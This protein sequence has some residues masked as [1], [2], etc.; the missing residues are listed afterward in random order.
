M[1][2]WDHTLP[3]KE[4]RKSQESCTVPVCVLSVNK[5][6]QENKSHNQTLLLDKETLPTLASHHS[7][8]T[9]HCWKR[10]LNVTQPQFL[11]S[12]WDPHLL[13][14]D[15]DLPIDTSTMAKTGPNPGSASCSDWTR[16]FAMTSRHRLVSERTH[17]RIWAERIAYLCS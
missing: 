13:E 11:L 3:G 4:I 9:M 1:H 17:I 5:D 8:Q 16:S 2:G 7:C 14:V 10:R 15:I 12:L 6:K